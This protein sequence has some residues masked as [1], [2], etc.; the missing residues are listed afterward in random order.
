METDNR[1]RFRA[2][3]PVFYDDED[4]CEHET[5]MCIDNV[6]VYSDGAIGCSE[7][8]LDSAV[9]NLELSESEEQSV[10]DYIE[11]NFSTE[12]DLWYFFDISTAIKEQCAG[13][14]DKIG[15]LIYEGDI[16]RGAENTVGT[17]K[18]GKHGYDSINVGFYIQW[19]MKHP[20]RYD[21][22]YWTAPENPDCI[23]IIGNIHEHK[24]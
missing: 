18:F 4:G 14:S 1:F 20:W 2:W 5:M 22:G 11:A 9:I 13:L 23:E 16:V 12:S 6:V 3:V 10:R 21:I 8:D 19:D 17:V 15:N 7:N 24:E